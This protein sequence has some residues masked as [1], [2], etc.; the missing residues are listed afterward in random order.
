VAQELDGREERVHVQ[1]G[2][3][4]L[5]TH[6]S[7]V[8]RSGN[9]EDRTQKSQ[10]LRKNRKRKSEDFS[11][12]P[13]AT[14]AKPSRLLRPAVLSFVYQYVPGSRM[15]LSTSRMSVRPQKA[16]ERSSSLRMISSAR[17]T[18]SWPIAPRPYS[19]ARPM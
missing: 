6:E 14:F 8:P 19:I 3:A 4:A 15:L 18:P 2:D 5:G 11:W 7:I 9:T 13:F 16:I 10:K 1:V 17:S 12:I